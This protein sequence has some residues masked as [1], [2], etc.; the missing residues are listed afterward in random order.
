MPDLGT[1]TGGRKMEYANV[2]MVMSMLRVKWTHRGTR[3]NHFFSGLFQ[4]LYAKLCLDLEPLIPVVVCGLRTQVNLT[5]DNMIELVC[6]GMAVLEREPVLKAAMRKEIDSDLENCLEEE[7]FDDAEMKRLRT[8]IEEGVQ[9]M[10]GKERIAQK[11]ITVII[12]R[13]SEE[14]RE[15]HFSRDCGT[16]ESMKSITPHHSG[17]AA[18][19]QLNTQPQISSYK[20]FLTNRTVSTGHFLN[21]AECPVALTPLNHIAGAVI[22]KYLSAISMHFI[23]ESPAQGGGEPAAQFHLLVTE[24][25]LIVRAHVASLGGNALLAYRAVPA[26][27]GGKVYKSQVYNVMSISGCAVQIEYQDRYSED[28]A[29]IMEKDRSM[30]V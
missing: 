19:Y 26:E 20:S 7:K 6:T 4:E 5:P 17:D 14:M 27:S 2:Q 18:A 13:L 30:S 3:N 8:G 15:L 9:N 23:R 28:V 10:F 1:G 16:E 22:K 11:Q 25:N 21:I 29:N 12:D 24:C